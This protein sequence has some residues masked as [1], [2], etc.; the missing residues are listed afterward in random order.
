MDKITRIGVDL[1]RETLLDASPLVACAFSVE[2]RAEVRQRSFA[3]TH[4]DA[5]G[6]NRTG[7]PRQDVCGRH[8]DRE[9]RSAFPC[10]SHRVVPAYLP[11]HVAGEVGGDARAV[12][13]WPRGTAAQI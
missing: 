12:E 13:K 8:L 2:E 5:L 9:A 11:R 7:Q 3:A 6:K 10:E 4:R 1:A